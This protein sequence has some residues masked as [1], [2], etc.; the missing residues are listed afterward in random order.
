MDK[1]KEAAD[2]IV[3]INK[4]RDNLIKDY[5][6]IRLVCSY[7]DKI[8]DEKISE[9]D[10]KFLIYISNI[11]GIPHFY[12]LL[13]KF[14]Q[15]TEIETFD[16]NTL[17]A[18]IY[19]STLKLDTNN[20]LHKYQ[21]KILNLFS[22]NKLNRYFLSAST[23]FGK[24]HIVFEIIRKM[25]YNNAVLIFPTIALLSENLERLTSTESYRFFC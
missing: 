2:I 4:Y 24:T 16:L 23:S 21:K 18:I 7:F 12:D 17:S 1:I 10:K 14:N 6:L 5:E 3:N 25:E 13:E 20:K 15:N 11:I 19:E 9:H 22:R 8:K